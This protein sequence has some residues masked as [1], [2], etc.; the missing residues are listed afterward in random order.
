MSPPSSSTRYMNLIPQTLRD[1]SIST[2]R[3][4]FEPFPN[5]DHSDYPLF[6]GVDFVSSPSSKP[7]QASNVAF[8]SFHH[9]HS[10]SCSPPINDVRSAWFCTKTSSIHA[11]ARK[12]RARSAIVSIAF[13]IPRIDFLFVVWDSEGSFTVS[14]IGGLSPLLLMSMKSGTK[15]RMR[16]RLEDGCG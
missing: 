10:S 3:V 15:I 13:S 7:R 14:G 16:A 4:D 6:L 11:D 5:L 1:P 8:P 12:L 9:V 2:S